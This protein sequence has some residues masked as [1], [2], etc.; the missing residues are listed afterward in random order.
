[1]KILVTGA[2]SGIGLAISSYLSQ[3]GHEIL[4]I[5]RRRIEDVQGGTN[6]FYDYLQIDLTT[7]VGISLL[8][9]Y[10]LSFKKQINGLVNN[11]GRSSWR[12]IERVDNQ[13]LDD[14]YKINLKQCFSVIKTAIESNTGLT[15]VVNVSSIAGRRGSANNSVYSAMKFGVIGLT[16]SLAKELGP[17]GIRVNAVSPVL[18]ETPGLIEA[19]ASSNSPGYDD[20]KQF[21]STFAASQSALGRLPTSDEVAKVIQFLLTDASSAVTGQNINVDCGVFPQ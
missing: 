5:G 8:D 2:S 7:D 15:S 3:Q 1:M 16:Q 6:F 18:I 17:K 9:N 4:G 13:F 12:S 10:L 21:L 19:L 14:M 20:Y 11:A